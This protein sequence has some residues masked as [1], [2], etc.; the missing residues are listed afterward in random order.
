VSDPRDPMAGPPGDP[1][2][3]R[4]APLI[5]SRAARHQAKRGRFLRGRPKP[6]AP[7]PLPDSP[8]PDRPPVDPFAGDGPPPA[9]PAADPFAGDRSTPDRPGG[10]PFAG[11]R[12]VPRRPVSDRPGA[13]RPGADW[14]AARAPRPAADPFAADRPATDWA[15]D[16]PAAD[17]AGADPAATGLPGRRRARPGGDP[18]ARARRPRPRVRP[19]P[20][21]HRGRPSR[22][23]PRAPADLAGL[24]GRGL[25]AVRGSSLALA[26]TLLVVVAVLVVAVNALP[27][28]KP[29]ATPAAR[30][31]YSARWV[32]P[33][34]PGQATPV[35]V[36]N[37][38][39]A[40]ASLRTVVSE[41]GKQAQPS[42]RDLAGGA[43]QRL[44]PRPQKPAYL[45]VE[46]FSAPVVVS[47]P[48]LGC[49]P[50]PGNR[51][52][53]PA[54][55]T[56]VGTDT[57]VIIVNPDSQPAVVD[58]V[59]H[60]TSG[61]IRPEREVFVQP[62][63]TVL[64]PL[65]DDA[66]AGL[67]PSI[68]VV[69][70]A[71]RVVV[72]ASVSNGGGAPTLLPAQGTARPAWAFAG[73]VSGGGRQAQVLVTN[74]NP[75]PLQ[76]DVRVT[77]AKASFR[78]PGEFGEPIANG[79]TAVLAIP[80]LDVQGPFA[81]QV[82]SVDGAAFVAALRVSRGDGS[83][84]SSRI[85]LGAGQPERGWLVPGTPAGGQVVLANVTTSVLEARLG[86]LDAGA[87]GGAPVRVPPGR[88]A[89]QKVP[90][91][92][93]NLLVQST[94]AGLV[95]APLNGGPIVPGSAIGGLPAG[96]PIVPGPAAAP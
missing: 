25:A 65:G 43:I 23:R 85:D 48:G 6:P 11:D 10:D 40:T 76:V 9:R 1:G 2:E 20:D 61:S 74:P 51:W 7:P 26:G 82:R 27:A 88:V 52:W 39:G 14:P 86:D 22:P 96:G 63:Q 35:T 95:A 58:L 50:G 68:E 31:P 36:A 84:I 18:E 30:D 78:P 8:T 44:S 66:P 62:G 45:Q 70:R 17:R 72:G 56:R 47:A 69:A 89:V 16:R 29:P 24:R 83:Q 57:Q 94:A 73:G 77:T 81:V 54:S 80:A 42:T 41:A 32:C 93:D 46:A 4:P 55:D 87:G 92:V 13:D 59:P 33:L 75:T 19:V 67:K 37:V 53:L 38:G 3:D 5:P 28:A 60:L 34:L 49:A 12:P 64:R 15:P 91:G 71:G 21:P 90:K 79:G